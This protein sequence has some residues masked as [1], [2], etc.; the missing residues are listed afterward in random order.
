MCGWFI[1]REESTKESDFVYDDDD[2]DEEGNDWDGEIEWT[3]P[4]ETER[5]AD[6]DVA[7]EST[8]YLDFLNKEV[9]MVFLHFWN[10][11]QAQLR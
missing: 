4:D 11:H 10:P 8:A 2:D 3:D 5:A 6:E 1:E 7:D 9:R